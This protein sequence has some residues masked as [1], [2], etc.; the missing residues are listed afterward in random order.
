MVASACQLPDFFAVEKFHAS[1]HMTIAFARKAKLAFGAGT[2][3]K[4]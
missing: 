4:S 2:P 3:S 1:W